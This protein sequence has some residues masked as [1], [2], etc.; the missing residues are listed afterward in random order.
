VTF[1]DSFDDKI[2]EKN[3]L[4]VFFFSHLTIGVRRG[5]YKGVEDGL[6]MP[7]LRAGHP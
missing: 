2:P 1:R 3:D 6:R 4:L 7:A 5:V